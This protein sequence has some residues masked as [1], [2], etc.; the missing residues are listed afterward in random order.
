M[1]IRYISDP[2]IGSLYVCYTLTLEGWYIDPSVYATY[3]LG[4][5]C[6]FREDA[7]RKDPAI[8]MILIFKP[9]VMD[10]SLPAAIIT[11]N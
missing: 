5:V 3:T 1:K 11:K 10:P 7:M 9:L 8:E 4:E 6:A 2:T